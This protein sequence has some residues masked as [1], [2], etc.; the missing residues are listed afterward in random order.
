MQLDIVSQKLDIIFLT[1]L[2]MQVDQVKKLA[3]QTQ[4]QLWHFDYCLVG[5]D[6]GTIDHSDTSHG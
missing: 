4:S 6:I 3:K 2:H 1:D 5:G